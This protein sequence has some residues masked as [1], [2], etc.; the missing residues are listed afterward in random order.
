MEWDVLD[1]AEA[2]VGGTVTVLEVGFFE[3]FGFFLV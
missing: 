2:M 3:E 1:Q